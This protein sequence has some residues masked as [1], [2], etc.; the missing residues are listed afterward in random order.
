MLVGYRNNEMRDTLR[1]VAGKHR[2]YLQEESDRVEGLE[3]DMGRITMYYRGMDGMMKCESTPLRDD[4]LFD[5]GTFR[6][7]RFLKIS[8]YSMRN[9]KKNYLH[10]VSDTLESLYLTGV[11]K[12]SLEQLKRFPN[13]N[14][15]TLID[16]AFEEESISLVPKETKER[17]TYLFVNHLTRPEDLKDCVNLRYLEA[18]HIEN[19]AETEV[20]FPNLEYLKTKRFDKLCLSADQFPKLKRLDIGNQ[21]GVVDLQKVSQIKSIRELSLQGNSLFD[22]SELENMS[23]TVLELSNN[24]IEDMSP[25]AGHKDMKYL[26]ISSNPVTD[27]SFIQGMKELELFQLD[28]TWVEDLSV[29]KEMK[30]IKELGI[31]KNLLKT[32]K[33]KELVSHIERVLER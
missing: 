8:H 16:T 29:L 23:L 9:E 18:D 12:N 26:S 24:M 17:L 2:A 5:I 13:L 30:G 10:K 11:S 7:L 20:V 21:Q 32:E 6:N 27:I 3:I 22:I 14:S 4:S 19:K 15:L 1:K 25:L 28:D 31:S 33:D